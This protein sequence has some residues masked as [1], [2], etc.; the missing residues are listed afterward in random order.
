VLA[1]IR[2][3]RLRVLAVAGPER[4]AI[5]PEVPTTAEAGLPGLEAIAWN[6]IFVPAGT[7]QAVI[8]TLHRELVRAYKAPEIES[9]L[10]ATG[11]YAAADTPEEFAAFVRSESDKWARIIRDAGIKPN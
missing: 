8:Q 11:S 1:S 10:R 9:Q 2:S 7:A 6:G 5:L 4:L 3:G